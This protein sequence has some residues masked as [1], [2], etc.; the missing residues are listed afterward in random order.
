MSGGSFSM[1]TDYKKNG[2]STE[3]EQVEE[4][5]TLTQRIFKAFEKFGD[6]FML[7]IYFTVSC[8]PVI[9][10]G[11]AFTALYTVTNRM[12]DNHE[13]SLWRDYFKAFRDN[14]KQ[15]TIIFGVD[16]LL[17]A[18]VVLLGT[19][20]SLVIVSGALFFLLSFALPLQF[21]LLARYKNTPGRIMFNSLLLAIAHPGAWFKLYFIWM[22]PVVVYY[23]YPRTFFYTC[24]LWALI[25][26]SL[27]AYICSGFLLK[28]YETIEAEDPEK[29]KKE[30]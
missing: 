20:P 1:E 19:Q 15:G 30:K 27:M 3:P 18:L 4:A 8:I 22:L 25:L 21:P 24:Y 5:L 12:H 9:T 2:D 16:L 14:F 6:L 10:A 26:T 29:N 17:I 28:F 11:A 13:G 7:N 23:F